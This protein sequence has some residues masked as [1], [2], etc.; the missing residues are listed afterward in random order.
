MVRLDPGSS[1]TEAAVVLDEWPLSWPGD[2]GGL[3]PTSGG[4]YIAIHGRGGDVSVSPTP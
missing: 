1:V 2:Y 4:R 3:A